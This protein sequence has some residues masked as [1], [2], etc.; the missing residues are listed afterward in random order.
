MFDPIFWSNIQFDM[1]MYVSP[2]LGVN[3]FRVFEGFLCYSLLFITRWDFKRQAF[4]GG[5][6]GKQKIR[7]TTTEKQKK[8]NKGKLSSMAM[9]RDETC[10]KKI[11]RGWENV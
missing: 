10:L 4:C 3:V 5:G 1:A 6:E 2:V 8:N 9:C 7:I 11:C